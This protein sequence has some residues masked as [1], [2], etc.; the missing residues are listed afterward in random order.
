L[1]L[2]KQKKKKERHDCH[3]LIC[4]LSL[5]SGLRFVVQAA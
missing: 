5:F 3:S 2:A 1:A 4:L